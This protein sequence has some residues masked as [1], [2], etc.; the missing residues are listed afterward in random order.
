MCLILEFQELSGAGPL[1]PQW[2]NPALPICQSYRP[3][4]WPAVLYPGALFK[5]EEEEECPCE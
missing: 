4:A 3:T 5:L 1:A 2:A